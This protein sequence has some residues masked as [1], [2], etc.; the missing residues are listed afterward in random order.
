[1][2]IMNSDFKRTVEVAEDM[3][4][5]APDVVDWRTDRFH[6]LRLL[7]HRRTRESDWRERRAEHRAA[8]RQLEVV[9]Q[10]MVV[11][12][13]LDCDHQGRK[14]NFANSKTLVGRCRDRPQRAFP[15]TCPNVMN[16]KNVKNPQ[17]NKK[18]K[19]ENTQT[20][21]PQG[22]TPPFRRL[23]CVVLSEALCYRHWQSRPS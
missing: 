2:K 3:Q 10:L 7:Q 14:I 12:M 20:L 13:E 16:L 21:D 1:M 8:Q 22:R 19:K 15:L 17:K 18:N 6:E 4:E 9:R 11:E 5:R 23:T